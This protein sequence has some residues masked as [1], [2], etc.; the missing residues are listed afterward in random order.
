M[1]F[2]NFTNPYQNPANVP[3]NYRKH[4]NLSK[5]FKTDGT[6]V[7]PAEDPV[8]VWAISLL[9]EEYGVPL[10]ALELESSADFSQGTHQ[11]GRRY[12]GWA[13]LIV[14]DDRYIG[15]GGGLDV[16]FIMVEAMEPSKKFEGTEA[17]GWIEHLTRLNAYMSASPSARYAVLTSGTHTKIY[18]RD[19]DYPRA[20][21]ICRSTKVLD[22]QQNIVR[23]R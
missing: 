4:S 1:P 22:W 8:T 21:Q 14:Y 7:R 2:T 18:R 15:A 23:I 12:Q 20:L 13:D 10:D 9:Y 17:E 11:G 6:Y 5:L 19:L 3:D 16:A